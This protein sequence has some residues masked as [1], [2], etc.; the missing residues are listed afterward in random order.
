IQITEPVAERLHIVAY[1]GL[2]REYLESF[3]VVS[4]EATSAC[5]RALRLRRRVVV[6]NVFEDD[7]YAPFHG[8][9]HATGFSALQS[10]PIRDN[11]DV[12]G[13]FSTLY[14]YPHTVSRHEAQTLDE[15]AEA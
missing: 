15:I 4:R 1:R 3:S 2:G 7:G 9:A 11:G 5:A 13:V 6:E 10:T 14:P 8:L 12:S